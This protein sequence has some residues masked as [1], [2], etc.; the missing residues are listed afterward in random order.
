MIK[1]KQPIPFI[2]IGGGINIPHIELEFNVQG[3]PARFCFMG[4]DGPDIN[5]ILVESPEWRY[6]VLGKLGE[7]PERLGRVLILQLSYEG[8]PRKTFPNPFVIL[9]TKKDTSKIFLS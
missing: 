5:S 3:T 6:E 8:W 9:M 7:I 4:Y 1:K 2:H